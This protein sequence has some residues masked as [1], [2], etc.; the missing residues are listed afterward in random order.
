MHFQDGVTQLLIELIFHILI[1]IKSWCLS[2]DK[3]DIFVLNQ[4]DA[5][6][7]KPLADDSCC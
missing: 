5:E 6:S 1:G 7:H 2:A 3:G 4:W